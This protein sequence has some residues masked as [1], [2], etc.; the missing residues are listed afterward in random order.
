MSPASLIIRN[1]RVITMDAAKPAAQA[2][3]LNGP[4]I[5]AVGSD[6][7]VMNLAGPDTRVIDAHGA[8][9]MPGFIESHLHIF[10]GSASLTRLDL[11]GVRGKQALS[12]V[13]A[14]W[15]ANHP[16]GGIIFAN[17]GSYTMFGDQPTTR[18]LLDDVCPD[19]PFAM[20]SP[21]FHTCWANTAALKAAGILHGR[22][23][24]TG[25]EIVMAADGTATGELLE[26]DAYL[27]VVALTETGGRESLGITTARD[28][29]PPASPQE[30]AADIATLR[31]GLDYCASLG[32]TSMHNMDGTV[33]QCEL[34]HEIEREHGLKCRIEVPFH[35]KNDKTLADLEEAEHMRRTWTSDFL[36]CSHVKL[37]MDGVLDSGTAFVLDG[38][39]DNPDHVGDPLFTQAEFIE[40]ATEVDRR[41]FQIAV[42]AIGDAAVR[43]TLDG[44]EAARNANGPRDSRHRIEHIEIIDEADIP[45]LA[46]LGVIASMQPLHALGTGGF[47]NE[48][49]AS[50]IG[51]AK[52]PR[53]FAWNTL[54]DAGAKMCFASDWPVSPVD[55]LLSLQAAMTREKLDPA[56]PDQRQS[57]HQVIHGY[58][59]G[60]AYAEF[61]EHRK[62]A[63]KPGYMADLVMLDGDIE[64]TAPDK[65][66]GLKVAL[67]IC[68]GQV[69][70][71]R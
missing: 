58:T 61:N 15:S 18:Q 19:R 28:P 31:K 51:K 66:T 8:T 39:P 52:L 57:L 24:I 50:R 68:G 49:T 67:T 13:L 69:T 45:R 10:H 7:D 26:P 14:D 32:I 5:A 71:E 23:C 40:I 25:S 44:Y 47:P 9:V 20:Q 3:A 4:L 35:Y 41:G 55:P 42:H 36:W 6:A 2:I 56:H 60:G 1:A 30:R 12:R 62:G 46:G 21:D 65:V 53:A 16:G 64:A 17:Q 29:H 48:P 33:Y 11:T 63:L 34:L 43:R 22:D 37:F 38:Y 59:A 54:R 70:H 27:D